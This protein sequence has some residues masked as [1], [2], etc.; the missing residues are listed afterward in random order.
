MQLTGKQIVANNIIR[1]IS[2]PDIQIQ[3]QGIDLKLDKVYEF[4]ELTNAG[5]IC[6]NNKENKI[7]FPNLIKTIKIDGK[8]MYRLKPGYYEV[9]FEEAC[10]IPSNN[11]LHYKTRSTLI[12]SG[13]V[14]HSGQ[15]DAGFATDKMGAFLH[16]IHPNGIIIEKGARVCQAICF[17]SG[18]VEKER[19]YG[20]IGG[21]QY[22]QNQK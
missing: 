2:E 4:T 16:V 21:S 9:Y 3:Q 18:D 12:R 15:F 5:Y 7:P 13:A 10:N 19:L 1:G 14:I 20:N 6:K 11:T 22:H 8:D 17:E